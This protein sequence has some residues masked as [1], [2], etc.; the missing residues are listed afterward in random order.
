MKIRFIIIFLI[1]SKILNSQNSIDS[2]INEI[3]HTINDSILINDYLELS[4]CYFSLNLDSSK[5]YL[6]RA[7]EYLNNKDYQ[8]LRLKYWNN[9]GNY[10]FTKGDNQKA[11]ENYDNGFQLAKSSNNDEYLKRF[12]INYAR[13]SIRNG[14]Y[15]QALKFYLEFES[16]IDTNSDFQRSILSKFY[17]NKSVCNTYL[18]KYDDAEKDIINIIKFANNSS[19]SL[20]YYFAYTN[21]L[22]LKNYHFDTIRPFFSKALDISKRNKNIRLE[23]QLLTLAGESLYEN[24]QN[25]EGLRYINNAITLSKSHKFEFEENL[26]KYHQCF[27]YYKLKKYKL[28]LDQCKNLITYYKEN[29]ETRLLIQCLDLMT[30]I[31]SHDKNY[32]KAFETLKDAD[33]LREK[34]LGEEQQKL[35]LELETQYDLNNKQKLIEAKEFENQ[36]QKEKLN[37]EK[38][39]KYF[40]FIILSI[41]LLFLIWALFNYSKKQKL[42]II[43]ESQKMDL[44]NKTNELAKTNLLKDKLFAMISHDLRSPVSNLFD[45][46]LLWDIEESLHKTHFQNSSMKKMK[47]SV[48]NLQHVLNN[49]LQ[50]ASSQIK[51]IHP[52]RQHVQLKPLINNIEQQLNENLRNKDIKLISYIE[53]EVVVFDENQLNI[54]LRNLISNAIKYSQPDGFILIGMKIE[55]NQNVLYIKD[56]GIGIQKDMLESIFNFPI[57][58]IGTKGERGTGIGLS[59]TKEL[60]EKNNCKLVIESQENIGTTVKIIF[61][62]ENII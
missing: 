11:K 59:I 39:Q 22:Y 44:Q 16:K 17:Q 54:V 40:I 2:L 20:N 26:A 35:A 19:D 25:E 45:N 8:S 60:I 37:I 51:N 41:A 27:I 52:N 13:L 5:F 46:M 58:V 14:N 49:V 48:E 47:L 10:F 34:T 62:N 30:N 42:N 56:K 31:Y 4:F 28:A 3:N 43:L 23:L 7:N 36:L 29:E 15:Y 55:L 61:K 12:T 9:L 50:W 1:L 18:K 57:S 33:A 32:K 53:D 6:N 38:K 21:L 24:N